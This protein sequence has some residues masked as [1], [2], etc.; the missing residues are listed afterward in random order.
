MQ[1]EQ[2][3]DGA[4]WFIDR[5]LPNLKKIHSS[6]VFKI[7]GRASDKVK[8]HFNSIDGVVCTGEVESVV[9][10]MRGASLGVCSVRLGAGVQNKVLDYMSVQ[11]PVVCSRLGSEGLQA[12]DEQDY[13]VVDTES[14]FVEAISELLCDEVKAKKI[15]INGFEYVKSNHSWA[16]KLNTFNQRVLNVI[17]KKETKGK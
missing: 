13:L 14:D 12:I 3:K 4:Q 9:A 15:G 16:V 1:S 10:E 6:V 8:K 5:V 7:I 2:N 17:S 11:L